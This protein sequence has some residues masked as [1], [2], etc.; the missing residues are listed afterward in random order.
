MGH[1]VRLGAFYLQD[2]IGQGGMGAVWRGVH[3]QRGQP[4]AVKVLSL[5]RAREPRS[6]ATFRREVRAVAQLNHEAIVSVLDHGIITPAAA[7]EARGKLVAGSPFLVMEL[8]EATLASAYPTVSWESTHSVLVRLLE[9]LAHAHARGIVHRDL[10]PANVLWVR[11]APNYPPDLKLSDFGLAHVVTQDDAGGRT[12]AAGTP[13]YMA[14]EQFRGAVRDF[15]PWT[16]LYAL[17]CLAYQLVSGRRPFDAR[18]EAELAQAHLHSAPLPLATR[19]AV[20]VGLEEW[21][22]RLLAKNPMARYRCAADA[23]FALGTLTA[24]ATVELGPDSSERMVPASAPP[25]GLAELGATMTMTVAGSASSYPSEPSSEASNEGTVSERPALDSAQRELVRHARLEPPPMATTGPSLPT[26]IT[27]IVPFDAE[28]GEWEHSEA[29]PTPEHWTTTQEPLPVTLLG[30]GLGLFGVREVPLVGRQHARDQMWEALRHVRR[31]GR[32]RAVVLEGPSGFGKTRLAT[33]LCERAHEVGSGEVLRAKHEP[34]HE[35]G[36]ALS[37]LAEQRLNTRGLDRKLALARIRRLLLAQGVDDEREWEGLCALATPVTSADEADA[38]RVV[39]PSARFALL[40][41]LLQRATVERPVVVLFDD[42]QWDALTLY[43]VE[44]VLDY[45]PATL[46]VLFVLTVQ[47]E[48]IAER[49]AE[50]VLLESLETR[51]DVDVIRIGPLDASDHHTLVANLLRFESDLAA[52][53]ARR[54]AGN[55]LFATQLIGD[56]VQRGVLELSKRGFVL[57]EGAAADLPDDLFTVWSQRV[58]RAVEGVEDGRVAL[59]LA[60]TFGRVVP[61][62]EWRSACLVLRLAVP[63]EFLTDMLRAQLMEV[64]DP[65]DV[66][67]TKVCFVHGMLREALERSARERDLRRHLHGAVADVLRP[68]LTDGET[69]VAERLALHLRAANR[70]REAVVPLRMAAD[71]RRRRGEI[72]RAL[73]LLDAHSSTLMDIEAEAEHVEWVENLL[74]RTELAWKQGALT[75]ASR[76]ADEGLELATR[77]QHAMQQAQARYLR[78]YLDVQLGKLDAAEPLLFQ[79]A[80]T[81]DLLG[82]RVESARAMRGL[83]FSA[84]SRGQHELA[85]GAYLTALETC[86]AYDDL[87]GAAASLAGMGFSD[88]HGVRGGEGHLEEALA[89]FERVGDLFGV[90]STLNNLA[91]LHRRQRRDQEAETLYRRA[92]TI[93]QSIGA[94]HLEATIV[95]G[96]ALMLVRGGRHD[97]ALRELEVA[98]RMADV[99]GQV[100]PLAALHAL[101]LPC[102]VVAKDRAAWTEHEAR[103]SAR[104]NDEAVLEAEVIEA[105]EQ[106]GDLCAQA[107]DLARARRAW[108][109]AA[110]LFANA[111]LGER[112]AGLRAKAT[113]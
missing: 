77:A 94:A 56:W 18:T 7:Y 45:A 52:N 79:A 39:Q 93:S 100:G 95:A 61:V 1:P 108:T 3:L 71:V 4:V 25:S 106:A 2:Q 37:R 65:L 55:P 34:D 13:A 29:P 9:A 85:F 50:R 73:Q 42:V 15:G 113:D 24:N 76:L 60:A 72:D 16:D 107:G 63:K 10:K 35:A 59:E 68:K 22:R 51:P 101:S 88:P 86:R 36:E 19:F 30:A 14:P 57:R 44:Y 104:V 70:L 97:E 83:G 103:L 110:R 92:L 17:G 28:D 69:E 8:A 43:F 6:L 32:P 58:E 41:R 91:D 112:A 75:R 111:G 21:V 31:E 74:M 102:A 98:W 62:D 26:V 99:L 5:E 47:E 49:P 48:A 96:L 23:L 20:P 109:L 54:T 78:G 46:P 105:V 81:L 66:G 84:I 82:R 64:E 40:M 38:L 27:D 67:M 11:R 80:Q 33:W 87:H 12:H 90:T 89:L 53:I